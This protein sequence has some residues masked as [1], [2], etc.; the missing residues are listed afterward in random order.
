MLFKG[1]KGNKLFLLEKRYNCVYYKKSY[2]LSD[3]LTMAEAI[4]SQAFSNFHGIDLSN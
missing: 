2:D 1:E 4:D 3:E